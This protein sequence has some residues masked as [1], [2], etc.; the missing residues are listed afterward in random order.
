MIVGTDVEI[1]E[2][3]KE[4][5][6]ESLVALKE[7]HAETKAQIE[8]ILKAL[9]D[10]HVETGVRI[11]EIV[12]GEVRTGEIVVSEVLT[13]VIT[14]GLR[15]EVVV[16][17]EGVVKGG[18]HFRNSKLPLSLLTRYLLYQRYFFA[19]YDKSA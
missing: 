3:L 4:I 17:E 6:A 10:N 2:V 8:E 14:E 9:K 19:V 7:D 11:E 12:V 18:L 15:E 1:L 5:D 13:A 16:E